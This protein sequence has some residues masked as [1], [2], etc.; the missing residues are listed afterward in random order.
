[1]RAAADAHYAPDMNKVRVGFFSFTEITDPAEHRAYNEWHMLDHMPEQ[2][3]IPGIVY[4][5]RWVSTPA[6]R[7]ERAVDEEPLAPVH[8]VTLYL[9]SDPIEPTLREFMDV[10]QQLRALGRFHL[11]RR[12]AVSGPHQ[13]LDAHAAPR[14]LVGAEAVPYRPNRGVYVIVEE[15]V[16]GAD[17]EAEDAWIRGLHEHWADAACAVPGVAGVWQFATSPRLNAIVPTGNRRVTV[18]YLDDAPLDVAERLRPLLA[19][20][21]DGA[22]VR[23]VHAG[24]YETVVPY[25]WDWFDAE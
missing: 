16:D 20:R 12:A 22:P 19:Q 3:P 10:G 15:P 25:Q 9:M 8:Y 2:Y 6:C 5:Q 7:A 18:C 24:P 21:W 1:M 23:P 11:H 17:P 14:V 13:W 4:G